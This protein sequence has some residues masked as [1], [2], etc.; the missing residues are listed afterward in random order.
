MKA[1]LLPVASESILWG[2]FVL[3]PWDPNRGIGTIERLFLLGPLVVA[4]LGLQ[5]AGVD[6]LWL[7]LIA[8]VGAA[9]SFLAPTGTIAG[10]LVAPWLAVCIWIAIGGLWQRRTHL[11][12]STQHLGEICR[13][14]GM[15][16]LAVGAV[17]LLQSRWGMQPL[18]FQEPLVLLVAVHFH[19]AAFVTPLMAA[20]VLDRTGDENGKMKWMLTIC[21]AGGSPLLAAGYLLHARPVRLTGATLL[22]VA[23]M[24]MAAWV[25][26]S[27]RKIEPLAARALLGVSAIAAV[28]AMVY[29][30]VYA[31]AD[32]FGEVWIAIPQMARTHG[33]LQAVGFSVCGLLGWI[34]AENKKE[35]R[36]QSLTRRWH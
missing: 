2:A 19:F 31:V 3:A 21:A 36:L 17:G 34:V 15:I 20:E 29:A 22:V 27:L 16:G 11:T 33:V 32:Y 30:S 12:P 14:V 1:K 23:L 25:L 8:A 6:S 4:P 35:L 9:I 18:G 7:L 13:V 24:M 28:V 26:W 10:M 5:L